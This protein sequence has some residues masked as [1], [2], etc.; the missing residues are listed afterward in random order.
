MAKLEYKFRPSKTVQRGMIVDV[1]RRLSV[2]AP[3]P[4]YQYVGF[5]G[6]EFIDFDLMHRALGITNMTSLEKDF[7]A[8]ERYEFNAPFK[9]V[10]VLAGSSSEQLIYVDW[11]P[12]SIVWL[13]YVCELERSVLETDIA[14]LCAR[15]QPGSALFVTLNAHPEAVEAK[16]KEKLAKNVG[17]DRI[18]SGVTGENLAIWG[19]ADVQR[20]ILTDAIEEGLRN[21]PVPAKW[22]QVLN[23]RYADGGKMQTLGGVVVGPGMQKSVE[24]CGFG[25]LDFVR[26]G[27]DALVIR[28][29]ML[30]QRERLHLERQVPLESGAS[31]DLPG[32]SQ[33]DKDAFLAVYRY[34]RL[35]S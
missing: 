21:R 3:L 15:L 28:V 26:T 22:H 35:A 9:T 31:L 20:T 23:I 27:K 8:I 14:L 13:D 7:R 24:Q 2:F 1:C 11:A 25:E 18:P 29:P 19:L 30:T 5:G 12:L 17:E 4:E 16:R 6:L 32:L 34:E 33:E 10:K